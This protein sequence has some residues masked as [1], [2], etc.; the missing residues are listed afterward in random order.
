[1]AP[2]A[3]G[4]VSVAVLSDDR[5]T[6]EGAV[7]ALAGFSCVRVLSRQN[8]REANVLVAF[9]D[10]VSDKTLER[11]EQISAI[12]QDMQVVLVMRSVTEPRL[13]RAIGLGVVSVVHTAEATFSDIAH[14]VV[15]AHIG[16]SDVPPQ[17][18]S[19][20]I[21]HL[22]R[23]EQRGPGAGVGLRPRDMTVLGLLSD[24]LD[25]AQ[26][27]RRLSYSERTIKSI[28][29]SI[30]STLGVSN[31]THAVAYVIRAGLL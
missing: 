3:A 6:Y 27:A 13:L 19:T 30:I 9:T 7:A 23:L 12:G 1:M 31:R 28:I 10:D 11:L 21:R 14:A 22:R 17:I 5:L 24:G 16:H 26:I 25:T 4:P 15:A 2:E 8:I 20:L 18:L 29:H